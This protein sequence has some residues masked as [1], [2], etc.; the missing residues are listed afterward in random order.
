MTLG[1]RVSGG[2]VIQASFGVEPEAPRKP[3][4]HRPTL[5]RSAQARPTPARRGSFWGNAPRPELMPGNRSSA[6]QAKAA[7]AGIWANAPCPEMMPGGVRSAQ[8]KRASKSSSVQLS[9][10]KLSPA[11]LHTQGG[12]P[13]PMSVRRKMESLLSADLSSV[14]VHQSGLASRVGAE[15]LTVGEDIHF[16][17]GRYQPGKREGMAL[18]AKQLTYVVQQRVGEAKNPFG[19]GVA[20][21]RE[22]RLDAQAEQVAVLASNPGA[23]LQTK[24]LP[25]SRG[26]FQVRTTPRGVGHQ[27]I[28]LYE[29]GRP[30]GGADVVVE[31]G[32]AKLYNLSIGEEHRG[33]GGGEKLLAAAA[34]ASGR[35]GKQKLRLDAQDDGSGRLMRW[36]EKQG[37]QRAGEGRDGMPA[38][39]ASVKDLKQG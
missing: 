38:F 20:L 23:A 1:P 26:I 14:R 15:A 37:F 9:P 24:R 5:S 6:V 36:Y 25:G 2:V 16:A 28:D 32:D 8:A 30:V 10:G 39:E 18:L 19:R 11:M 27:H 29:H 13:L 12:Q 21:V 7:R 4:E 34:A 33:R 31:R 3:V 35:I 17:G 22:P